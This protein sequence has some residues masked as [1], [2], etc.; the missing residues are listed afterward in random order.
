MQEISLSK[1]D[2]S[3][4]VI[5]KSLYW[6]SEFTPWSLEASNN[7]WVVKLNCSDSEIFIIK[8]KLDELLNDNL[9]RERLDLESKHIRKKIIKSVL[10]KVFNVCE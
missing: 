6:L 10:T 9:L 5:R 2:Y 4:N 8:S 3:E 1:S 7:M